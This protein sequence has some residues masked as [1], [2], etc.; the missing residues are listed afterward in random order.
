MAKPT[1]IVNIN[2]AK[3]IKLDIQAESAEQATDKAVAAIKEQIKQGKIDF[4]I[5]SSCYGIKVDKK[6]F[7][8]ESVLIDD[9]P[10]IMTVAE[11]FEGAGFFKIPAHAGYGETLCFWLA[12]QP[13]FELDGYDITLV[14][15][16]HLWS[17]VIRSLSGKPKVP[18]EKIEEHMANYLAMAKKLPNGA[19]NPVKG[20]VP[21]GPGYADDAS[22]LSDDKEVVQF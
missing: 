9:H 17:A 16:G 1:Y 3:D 20:S 21:V 7:Y 10:D 5:Y 4:K 6:K 2:L 11:Y 22:R 13:S 14:R 15:V 8:V 12:K 18:V 19:K